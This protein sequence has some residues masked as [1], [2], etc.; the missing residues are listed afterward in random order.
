MTAPPL[1]PN[2]CSK[3]MWRSTQFHDA[4]SPGPYPLRLGNAAYACDGVIR[5]IT[6]PQSPPGA[7]CAPATTNQALMP[8]PLRL[9]RN[10]PSLSAPTALAN[11]GPH[12]A[13]ACSIGLVS[14]CWSLPSS[15]SQDLIGLEKPNTQDIA[16]PRNTG[17][18][19]TRSRIT[20]ILPLMTMG[21][22]E[23]PALPDASHNAP[24]PC[25][26]ASELFALHLFVFRVC[27]G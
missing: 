1:L 12:P 25:L 13:S 27:F 16:S 22:T 9:T 2:N 6:A 26:S 14:I 5:P 18:L 8:L 4:A 23:A 11:T 3:L 17:S 15:R 20:R 19:M 10:T 21:S 24:K 7:M